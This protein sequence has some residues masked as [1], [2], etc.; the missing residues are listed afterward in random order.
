MFLGPSN[1]SGKVETAFLLV[2]GI[3]VALLVLVTCVMI[4]F[5]I[6]YNS[7]RHPR[8]Q[9]VKESVALEVVW[10]V[11]PVALVLV[12]S[13]FGWVDFEYVR[14][15]P[16][17]AMPVNVTARQWSRLF[18]Y[19]NGRKSE[20]LRVPG[21]IPVKLILTSEDVIHSLYIPAYRIKEDCVPGM[22]THLWFSAR[23]LGSYDIFCTEYC[24]VA[25][26]HMR[27]HVV[28]MT[29]DDFDK[30]YTATEAG[31]LAEKG[32]TILKEKGCLGCHSIDG[33]QKIGPTLKGTFGKK[34]RVLTDGKEREVTADEEYLKMSI[35]RPA[36]D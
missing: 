36:A 19:E 5:L 9:E 12:M 15:P 22:K 32:L 21:C 18:A 3:S 31:G 25:H 33:S 14:N 11:V 2:V 27:S 29:D 7:K 13:Y 34:V 17:N 16:K 23:E 24:G 35:L 20:L 28:V 8:S 10:T 26:S 1:T 6:R 4:V 30:W